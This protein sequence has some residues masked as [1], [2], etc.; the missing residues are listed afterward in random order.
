MAPTI[1]DTIAAGSVE[2]DARGGDSTNG[3]D[4]H[5][6]NPILNQYGAN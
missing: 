3:L 4:Y 2:R 6:L 1:T 5:A